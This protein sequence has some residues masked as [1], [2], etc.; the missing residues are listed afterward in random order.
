M[1]FLLAAIFFA[2]NSCSSQSGGTA[3][4]ACTSVAP[5]HLVYPSSGAIG[6]P[7]GN[8]T[9]SVSYSQ[10]PGAAFG[11]PVL[12]ADTAPSVTGGAWAAGS[13]GRWNS[14]IGALAAKTRY[15]VNVTNAAC[16]QTY[17]IGYFATQ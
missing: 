15:S 16:N 2:V 1:R 17:S 6:V 11:P 14:N 13:A 10:N 3:S 8:F 7:D 4:T 12:T 9:L 5:P